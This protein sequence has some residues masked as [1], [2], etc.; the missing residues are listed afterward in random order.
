[1]NDKENKC[2]KYE[3]LFV[4]QNEEA[5]EKHIEECEECNKENEKYK[6]ISML[7]KE[8]ASI[9]LE[10]EKKKK[11]TLITQKIACYLIAFIA[12]S[13]YTGYKLY[14]NYT[15][16]ISLEQESY[17]SEMGLPIDEYGFLSI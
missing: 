16:Q 8:V 7:V 4:F 6:K 11:I 1:M 17:V 3:S 14:D 2:N 15:Y 10:K 12:L 9:Y 13:A 5:L